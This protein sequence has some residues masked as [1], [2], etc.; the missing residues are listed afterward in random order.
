[1]NY[2]S[3]DIAVQGG[4]LHLGIWG[5][6]GP[7]LLCSH[8]L[9]ANHRSFLGLARELAGEYRLVAVDHRGRGKSAN[10]TGPWG[11]AEHADDLAAALDFL[12]I[13]SVP[14]LIGHSM[15]AFISAVFNHRHPGRAEQLM[16][17]DGGLPLADEIPEGVTPEQLVTAVVGPAMERLDM[18]FAS[19]Q[20][21]MDF[22]RAH[23]AISE[24]WNADFE[25]YLRYELQGSAPELR[26]CVN[27][28]AIIG[29]AKSQLMSDDIPNALAALQ[30]PT[31]FV[32]AP[33]GIMNTEPL[34]SKERMAVMQERLPQMQVR[35]LEDLN[36]Y[37]ILLGDKGAKDLARLVRDL[38]PT[39]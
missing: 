10:I 21:F 7:T 31:T 37:S 30:A 33:R 4:N 32:H 39:E 8:G 11:M 22:W 17:I 20:A 19:E 6:T 13:D 25:D 36:H 9:T 5:N 18:A 38:V 16:F 29:D 27:K 1:M 28:E 2:Q 35:F 14:L 12:G 23:P 3:H 24:C 34:Y 15:G 26:S